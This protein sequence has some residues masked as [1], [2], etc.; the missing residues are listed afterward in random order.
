MRKIAV[1]I[2]FLCSFNALA[3]KMI[4]VAVI[5][6]GLKAEYVLKA[7]LC[8]TG[9]KDFTKTGFN[10]TNGHGTNIVGLIVNNTQLKNYCI[11]VIKAY[12]SQK[13]YIT[14]ALQHAHALKLEV[15]NISGGGIG[16][17]PAE[18][19]AI[20][21]LLDLGSTLVVAAGNNSHNLDLDCNFYP[22][23]YDPR[24]YVVG[25]LSSQSNYGKIV[26]I[27]YNG[28]KQTAFGVTLSG[29]S[30]ATALFTA[31]VLNNIKKELE[32]K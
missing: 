4:R 9:H 11:V 3:A 24:I 25:N 31:D 23:C 26:D 17:I 10:D 5:D 16:I 28:N 13:S 2:T 20:L 27:K 7:K 30:Q 1:L 15:I 8:P 19:Q 12:D 6:S 32:K 18:R 29:S 21:S 22:A 14:E